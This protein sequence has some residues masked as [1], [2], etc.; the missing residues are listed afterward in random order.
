MFKTPSVGFHKSID[1]CQSTS[2]GFLT[3]IVSFQ[4]VMKLHCSLLMVCIA[5]CLAGCLA[6]ASEP[7]ADRKILKRKLPLQVNM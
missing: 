4:R 3:A 1:C 6:A 5:G 2:A 7:T